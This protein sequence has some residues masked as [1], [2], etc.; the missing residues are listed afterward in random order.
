MREKQ[1][2]LPKSALIVPSSL[3]DLFSDQEEKSFFFTSFGSIDS[4]SEALIVLMK[5][6]K[7]NALI[8]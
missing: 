3:T 1:F 5:K 2:L 7:V 8:E 6:N 4:W